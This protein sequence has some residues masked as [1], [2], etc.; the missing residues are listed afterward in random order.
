MKSW[1]AISIGHE[2]RRVIL[3]EIFLDISS[4]DRREYILGI[5]SNLLL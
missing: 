2:K 1:T 5:I 4:E 3:I